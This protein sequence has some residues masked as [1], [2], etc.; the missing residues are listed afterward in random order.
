M[1]KGTLLRA[2]EFADE[3]GINIKDNA[4]FAV[5]AVKKATRMSEGLDPDD[6]TLKLALRVLSHPVP[7][8]R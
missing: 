4:E 7:S 5:N 2:F 8:W 6:R 3:M 1:K